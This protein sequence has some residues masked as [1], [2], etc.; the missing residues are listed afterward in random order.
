MLRSLLHHQ[1][2]K[3]GINSDLIIIIIIITET[4][5]LLSLRDFYFP[6]ALALIHPFIDTLTHQ[7]PVLVFVL[8][9]EQV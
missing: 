7:Q 3:A 5:L 2:R 4:L 6:F 1:L 8:R 9:Y